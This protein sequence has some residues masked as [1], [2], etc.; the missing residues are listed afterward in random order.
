MS[1]PKPNLLFVFTD[2]HRLS[3]VGAYGSTP[4]RTPAIDR[5]ASEGTRFE[6]AYT[7]CPVCS[8]ARGTVMAG[9]YPHGH[10]I[11]SNV[12]NLGCTVHQIPD[13]PDL[14]SRRLAGAG[15]RCGYTGKW[16]LGD[17]QETVFSAPSAPMLPR[18][19]GFE[20]QNFPGHGGGGFRYPEYLEYLKR[21]GWE[22]CVDSDDTV[23]PCGILRGP[24]ASTVPHF[25]TDHTLSLLDR[26]SEGDRPFFI[27][28]NFWGPHGPYYVPRSYYDLYRDVAIPPWPNY[29]WD[30]AVN[31][32]LQVKRHAR[33]GELSWADWAEA[34]RYY[35]AFT[36]LI[37][38]QIGRLLAG[39]AARGLARNT[40][41]VFAAD[42]GETLG[43]HGGLTDKGWH[44]FEE[45][46]RIPFIVRAPKPWS[47]LAPGTV[48]PQ[49]VSLADIYPTFCDLAGAEWDP[50]RVHGRS[51]VRLLRGETPDWP[52]EAVTEFHGVNSVAANMVSIR[53]GNLKYGWN[54]ANTD[55]L[56]DLGRDP[57][58]TVNR[59]AE[60]EYADALRM[61]REHLFDWMRRTG[62]PSRSMFRQSRLGIMTF[63]KRDR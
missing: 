29:E 61:M 23:W 36:T 35:Y 16:H 13:R 19:V 25:L 37:D 8:P 32:P 26:F 2:Q 7:T 6:T 20:G 49:W 51:L 38:H 3:A 41:V 52:D 55:E 24:E 11:T 15:Y 12:H 28:H 9:L 31:L 21:H 34:I 56:Y 27:W 50:D 54:C 14:L 22:H 10:G 33:A 1:D 45:I 46:Q 53:R 18:D 17:S 47:G 39:L 62:H 4:C 42:H 48:L 44:H 30:S 60:P 57:Q 58:E 63:E 40:I 43:S 5:L 59:V